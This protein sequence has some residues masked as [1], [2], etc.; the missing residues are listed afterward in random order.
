V[1]VERKRDQ[2]CPRSKKASIQP[3]NRTG[4]QFALG[5]YSIAVEGVHLHLVDRENCRVVPANRFQ[6]GA[7][8]R[9]HDVATLARL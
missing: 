3:L 8:D 6:I 1:T 4:N 9:Q 5:R 7:G 2:L